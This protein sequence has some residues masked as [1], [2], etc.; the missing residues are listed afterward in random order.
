MTSSTVSNPGAPA[1]RSINVGGH[2]TSISLEP[3][4]W[5]EAKP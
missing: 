1:K 2:R 5:E 3:V 4:F